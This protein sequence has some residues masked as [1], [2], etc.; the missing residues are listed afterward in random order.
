MTIG[1]LN[2][3]GFKDWFEALDYMISGISRID[4]DTALIACGAYGFPLAAEIKKMG[5]QAVCMGGVLQILFGILGRRWDGSRFGGIAHI[6]EQLKRYYNE[7]WI[8]L[9]E[10]RP[11][12][13]DG[14][15][16]G[17]YWK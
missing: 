6:P 16:Y 12:A 4:F 3:N 7:T 17:P 14:V 10:E 11:A 9:R 5:R 15:E 8:Y 13:A 1:D 2:D